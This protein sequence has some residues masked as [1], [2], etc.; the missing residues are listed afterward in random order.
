M[1]KSPIDKSSLLYQ[2]VNEISFV[3]FSINEAEFVMVDTWVLLVK[4]IAGS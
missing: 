1:D 4:A 2:K 3:N